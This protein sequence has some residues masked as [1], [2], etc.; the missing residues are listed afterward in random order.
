MPICKHCGCEW[1]WYET[2]KKMFTI[3]H[4]LTCPSCHSFQYLTKKSRNRMSLFNFVPLLVF[5]PFVSFGISIGYLLLLGF[6]VF[7]TM[8]LI[9]PFLIELSNKEE[10]MW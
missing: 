10:P 6:I 7:L 8:F 9:M 3:K 1:S 2:F 5:I 4:K